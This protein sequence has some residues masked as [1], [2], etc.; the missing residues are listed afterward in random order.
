MA[1]IR[2]PEDYGLNRFNLELDPISDA[3]IFAGRGELKKEAEEKIDRSL[4]TGTALHMMLWGFA[5]AGKTHTLNYVVWYLKNKGYDANI[6][7]ICAPPMTKNSTFVDLYK[8]I[9][10][11]LGQEYLFSL[12]QAIYDKAYPS[13][14]QLPDLPSRIGK[15]R[16]V[17]NDPELAS[18]VV[19]HVAGGPDRRYD[20][21]KWLCG[22][23]CSN[24][25]KRRLNVTTDNSDPSAALRTLIGLIRANLILG[26]KPLVLLLDELEALGRPS[27]DYA[28][29]FEEAFRRLAEQTKQFVMFGAFTAAAM[30]EI[31][32]ITTDFVVGRI[33][34]NNYKEVR[35]FDDE[36]SLEFI[37]QLLEQI[38]PETDLSKLVSK[39]KEKKE[40]E[41]TISNETFPY[42]KEAIEMIIAN[43]EVKGP[44]DIQKLLTDSL[45]DAVVNGQLLVT[46]ENVRKILP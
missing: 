46:S 29:T 44:R 20:V 25:E 36:A 19:A 23:S 38:R 34:K 28:K 15:V 17:I 31:P 11:Q 37:E 2:K 43:L 39:A 21:W 8:E 14:A 35:I 6:F 27:A 26:G 22:E 12:I 24:Q 18:V 41:E 16:D 10:R 30:T 40:T 45:G 9:I 32:P 5:G 1:A 4:S 33:G 7:Y 42:T 13:L 3:H